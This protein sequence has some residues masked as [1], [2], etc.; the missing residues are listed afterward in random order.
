MTRR[1][2][3]FLVL[4]TLVGGCGKESSGSEASATSTPQKE[5]PI[6][7]SQWTMHGRYRRTVDVR[8]ALVREDLAAVQR[9]ARG[10]ERPVS[11]PELPAEALTRSDGVPLAA[12]R[13]LDATST[14]EAALAFADVMRACGECHQATR[15][16]WRAAVPDLP[17]G[18]DL[19]DHMRRYSFGIDRMWE[20]LLFADAARFSRGAGTF[21]A[22]NFLGE[23][24]S[25]EENPP[26]ASEISRR[27]HREARRAEH[28]TDLGAQA[29]IFGAVLTGCGECHQ[30]IQAFDAQNDP[31]R[32]HDESQ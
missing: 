15:V 10:L 32:N 7:A 14:S 27:I 18:D 2:L 9:L 17:E 26:G 11:F 20:G 6:S 5:A 1:L 3:S 4:G 13:I 22:A 28:A 12:R 8:N 29:A 30:R 31:T 25:I 23:I 16:R 19:T 21:A 24:P